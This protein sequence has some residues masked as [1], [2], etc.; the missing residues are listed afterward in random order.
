MLPRSP[1]PRNS[2]PWTGPAAPPL[3]APPPGLPDA[4]AWRLLLQLPAELRH[5]ILCMAVSCR[6][7]VSWLQHMRF[8]LAVL[9]IR[10]CSACGRCSFHEKPALPSPQDALERMKAL[11]PHFVVRHRRPGHRLPRLLV[12]RRLARVLRLSPWHATA[13]AA[14]AARW[15]QDNDAVERAEWLERWRFCACSLSAFVDVL[16]SMW[17]RGIA[18]YFFSFQT[19]WEGAGLVL[20]IL[21]TAA[22]LYAAGAPFVK[23]RW[24]LQRIARWGA[25]IRCLHVLLGCATLLLLAVALLPTCDPV[26]LNEHGRLQQLAGNYILLLVPFA[27]VS[28]V[29]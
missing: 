6:V 12:C 16:C 5:A 22:L 27:L 29:F 18:T 26:R 14:Y 15:L 10:S 17:R 2:Q 7:W 19:S 13:A 3:V 1:A 4:R 21:A 20:L 28:V 25:A 23:R 24:P 9:C 8:F 11:T